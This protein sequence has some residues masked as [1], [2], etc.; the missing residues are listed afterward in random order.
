MKSD[1]PKKLQWAIEYLGAKGRLLRME[2]GKAKNLGERTYYAVEGALPKD[3]ALVYVLS[4]DAKSRVVRIA[5]MAAIKQLGVKAG[6]V[7]RLP[8]EGAF[9]HNGSKG[10]IHV[11]ATKSVL[12]RAKLAEL[13]GGREPPPDPT[14]RPIT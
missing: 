3:R 12:T 7:V 1:E 2:P 8:Q 9:L 6:S 4:M 11:V 13:I 14:E 5:L 10:S